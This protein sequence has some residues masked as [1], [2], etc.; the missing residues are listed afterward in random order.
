MRKNVNNERLVKKIVKNIMRMAVM[1][2]KYTSNAAQCYVN[3]RR[4]IMASVSM[5]SVGRAARLSARMPKNKRNRP[6]QK[7]RRQSTVVEGKILFPIDQ[8]RFSA[9]LM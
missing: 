6:S 3:Q 1:S 4:I 8:N 2:A 7:E 5:I 9:T